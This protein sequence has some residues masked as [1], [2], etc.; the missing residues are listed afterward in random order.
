MGF[1]KSPPKKEGDKHN[2]VIPVA[3]HLRWD[4]GPRGSSIVS[5]NQILT[6]HEELREA[7]AVGGKEVQFMLDTGA[8]FCVLNTQK[9][10]LSTENVT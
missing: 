2:Q 5:D 8:T 9:C 3:P 4:A 7:L 6:S 1:P 10:S